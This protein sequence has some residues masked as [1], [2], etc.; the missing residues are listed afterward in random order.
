MDRLLRRNVV[1]LFACVAFG[2]LCAVG[3]ADEPVRS[4]TTTQE[5]DTQIQIWV[6]Q[7]G[8]NRFDV[9]EVASE[10]LEDAGDAAIEA[11][12][13]GTNS[14]SIEQRVRALNVLRELAVRDSTGESPAEKSIA[15][16]AS[17]KGTTIANQAQVIQDSLKELRSAR[18]KQLLLRLGA[19]LGPIEDL[20][21]VNVLGAQT[22]MLTLDKAWRGTREDLKAVNW[23]PQSV[24]I[25]LRG[26]KFTDEW[27][28][29]VVELKN[30]AALELNRTD[31]TDEAMAGIGKLKK[32]RVLQIRYCNKLTDGCLAQ[33][34][35]LSDSLLMLK[36]FDRQI[37]QPGFDQLV[38]KYPEWRTRFGRGAFLGVGG[39]PNRFGRGCLVSRVSPNEAAEKAGLRE[40]DV[41]LTY[42]GKEV[43][44]FSQRDE[45]DPENPRPETAVLSDLIS[46]NFEGDKVVLTVQRP[47]RRKT[48]KIEVTLGA[49]D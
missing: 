6:E 2:L 20:D 12:R 26:E 17:T 45:L 7:L 11:L 21:E 16:I 15:Q 38:K 3:F 24:K 36:I 8:S 34:N 13:R 32:L 46:E 4:P 5:K 28:D 42:D 30:V 14:G 27:L 40:R 18:A 22:M 49:W 9:R 1:L 10:K 29:A 19:R 37:T 39:V 41:I 33:I 31:T 44:R 48:M 35:S 47:G 23:L 25:R 43:D